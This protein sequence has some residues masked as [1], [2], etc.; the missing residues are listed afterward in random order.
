MGVIPI[1]S[2]FLYRFGG[3]KQW[4]WCILNQ[5]LWRYLIGWYGIYYAFTCHNWK[6]AL[7]V[8]AYPIAVGKFAYGENSWLNFL[9]PYGKFFVSGLAFGSCSFILLPFGRALLQSLLSGL[10]FVAIKYLDDRK[11]II[12][13][14]VEWLRGFMGTILIW[15]FKRA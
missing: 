14:V 5:K 4:K 10:S 2:G 12:N 9:G 7:T 6:Y 8:V 15:G 1:I 11:I 3:T 13:P